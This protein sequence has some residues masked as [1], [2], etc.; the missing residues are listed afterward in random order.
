MRLSKN[1]KNYQFFLDIKV[2]QWYNWLT[3]IFI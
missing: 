2:N 3:F 1:I